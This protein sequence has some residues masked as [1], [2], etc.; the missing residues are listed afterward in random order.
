MAILAIVLI[1]LF[2]SFFIRHEVS[3]LRNEKND[4]FSAIS[5]LK[6]NQLVQWSSIPATNWFMVTKIDKSE[7]YQELNRQN[8]FFYIG[9]CLCLL[10]IAGGLTSFYSFLR[11]LASNAMKFTPHGGRVT[12]TAKSIPS[13]WVEISVK[14]TGIGMSIEMVENLFQIEINTSRKGTESEPSS[15]LGLILCK[16]FV[17]KHGGKLWVESEINMGSTFHFTLPNKIKTDSK[18]VEKDILSERM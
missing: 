2:G 13:E 3:K 4:E 17:E 7:F 15:G 11:N 14:D 9:L 18:P 1:I 12:I 5:K 16:D 8:T 10:I 6:I